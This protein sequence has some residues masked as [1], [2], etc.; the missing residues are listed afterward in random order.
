MLQNHKLWVIL[1]CK[2]IFNK[3]AT[4]WVSDTNLGKF[5]EIFEASGNKIKF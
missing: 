2:K 5:G 1:D 4:L 3:M